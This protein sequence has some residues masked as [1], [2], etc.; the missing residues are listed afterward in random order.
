MTQKHNW[1]LVF[2]I[3]SCKARDIFMLQLRVLYMVT[4]VRLKVLALNC[5]EYLNNIRK[6]KGSESHKQG[7]CWEKKKKKKKD[8]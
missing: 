4:A 7:D 6:S 8:Y 2:V 1:V 3:N 5:W